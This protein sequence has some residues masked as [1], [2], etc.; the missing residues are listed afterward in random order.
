MH[1]RL[2]SSWNR[3]RAARSLRWCCTA[4]VALMLLGCQDEPPPPPGAPDVPT[5]VVNDRGLDA[6]T[7]I[8]HDS[9]A[10][11]YLVTNA[12]AAHGRPGEPG[13]VARLSPGGRV[14]DRRWIEGGNRQVELRAPTAM[15]IRGDTL[16]VADQNCVR[17]FHRESGQPLGSVCPE[18]AGELA[19]LTVRNR[20]VYV[21][22]RSATPGNGFSVITIDSLGHVSPVAGSE[23]VSHPSGI[24][25]GPWGLFVTRTGADY[26][27][28]LT[29]TGPRPVLRGS[30]RQTGGIVAAREGSFAFSNWTDSAVHYVD[31]RFTK[32]RGA[33]YTLARQL[34]E[35]GQLG[36]D[37]S[38]DRILIPEAGRNRITFVDLMNAEGAFVPA[39]DMR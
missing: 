18:G 37:A 10:D 16:F 14:L 36:Y 6:P 27:S 31:V 35:P 29:P 5:I 20:V 34:A 7:A 39:Y 8:I 3:P 24:A 38:R 25:A 19:G 4:T 28:Q 9:R 33:L 26:V 23:A 15:T 21:I 13:F 12:P 32:G 22:D 30:A 2:I 17:L 11:V 1:V